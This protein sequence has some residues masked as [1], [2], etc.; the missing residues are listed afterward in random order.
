MTSYVQIIKDWTIRRKILTGFGLVLGLTG[1]LGWR[2]L[3]ALGQ[4]T[5]LVSGDV[6]GSERIVADSRRH[7]PWWQSPWSQSP[8]SRL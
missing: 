7:W 6:A 5:R 2:A 1:L 3:H 4:M 8:W